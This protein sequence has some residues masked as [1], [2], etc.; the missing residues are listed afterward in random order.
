MNALL[1][2]RAVTRHF[3]IP[4]QTEPLQILKGIDLEVAEGDRI[5]II[6]RSGSGKST[7]LNIM[8]LLDSPSSGEVYY[9]GRLVNRLGARSRDRIRAR[10]I[11]FV[12][13]QFNLLQGRTALDNVIMPLLYGSSVN[14]W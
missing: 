1:S 3:E 13:Q 5:A 4:D 11:G 10:D 6:G 14:F 12:F 8:G 7:L 2:L 9:R